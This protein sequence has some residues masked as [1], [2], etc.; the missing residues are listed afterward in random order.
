MLWAFSQ[1]LSRSINERWRQVYFKYLLMTWSL[2]TVKLSD[3][4]SLYIYW[5][6][7]YIYELVV[8]SSCFSF[9]RKIYVS[10][11]LRLSFFCSIISAFSRVY[12]I[13]FSYFRCTFKDLSIMH[14]FSL[15]PQYIRMYLKCPLYELQILNVMSR[16]TYTT[17]T[18]WLNM[19][20]PFR[21]GKT[22]V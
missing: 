17:S 6:T 8:L 10:C 12:R 7:Y 21:S 16:A 5:L 20:A 22:D 15:A 19:V 14:K 4:W 18:W 9:I 3:T 11:C 13:S 2:G 1:W